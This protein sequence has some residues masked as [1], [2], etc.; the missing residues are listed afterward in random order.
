MFIK[1]AESSQDETQRNAD[2]SEVEFVCKVEPYI[3][4][5]VEEEMMEGTGDQLM[6]GIL[7]Y[8]QDMSEADES[9]SGSKNIIRKGRESK[10]G[11]K[12]FYKNKIIIMSV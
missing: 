11:K 7:E 3:K 1:A 10:K 8:S 5:E 12:V 9:V 2:I 4:T 6:E